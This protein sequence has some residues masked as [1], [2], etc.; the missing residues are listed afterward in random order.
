MRFRRVFHGRLCRLTRSFFMSTYS[1]NASKSKSENQ[2]PNIM[3]AL[4]PFVDWLT[5]SRTIQGRVGVGRIDAS[6]PEIRLLRDQQPSFASRHYSITLQ[7]AD[8]SLFSVAGLGCDAQH[9]TSTGLNALDISITRS[10][11][12]RRCASA[13]VAITRTI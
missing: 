8:F 6:F 2:P 13:A 10:P 1:I 12:L 5:A 7:M 4:L 3:V 9:A 11:G